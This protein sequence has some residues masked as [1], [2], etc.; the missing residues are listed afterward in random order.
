MD[1]DYTT[2]AS[3]IAARTEVLGCLILSRDGLVL[4]AFPPGGE[5]VVTPAW[6][7]FAEV[8]DP[9]RGFVQF[10]DRVW[11]YASNDEY[12]A[13]AVAEPTTRPG[14]LIEY[15]EQVLVAAGETRSHLLA[16]GPAQ[17]VYLG[18]HG[19]EA[20]AGYGPPAGQDLAGRGGPQ[21]PDP[22]ANEPD[23]TPHPSTADEQDEDA[24]MGEPDGETR[25]DDEPP[26]RHREQAGE[27]DRIALAREFS[28][29]Q[30]DFEG[31][32]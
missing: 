6:L 21:P 14:I 27:V 15:L 12:A 20:G 23:A 9:R 32:E 31:A 30:E 13:F 22:A 17:T 19:A 28:G 8:G 2:L 16:M 11:A 4:G 26:H 1:P 25:Q 29:L 18:A 10:D 5:H 24:A 7:R 3:R